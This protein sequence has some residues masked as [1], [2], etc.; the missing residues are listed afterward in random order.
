MVT[1]STVTECTVPFFLY[2]ISPKCL[3]WNLCTKSLYMGSKEVIRANNVSN[4]TENFSN[5]YSDKI[6][7]NWKNNIK[8]FAKEKK[9]EEKNCFFSLT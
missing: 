6:R 4:G 3:H 9:C 8:T 7:R 1:L 2:N 5:T